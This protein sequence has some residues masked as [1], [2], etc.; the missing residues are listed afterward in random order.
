[1]GRGPKTR[2]EPG[3][4]GVNLAV[5]RRMVREETQG[6]GDEPGRLP[7]PQRC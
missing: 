7:T 3:H 6:R 1:M 2:L 5:P 4:G